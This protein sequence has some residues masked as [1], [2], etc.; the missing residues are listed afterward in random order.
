MSG[1][2]AGLRQWHNDRW[3]HLVANHGCGRRCCGHRRWDGNFVGVGGNAR[4][5][6]GLRVGFVS[7]SRRHSSGQDDGVNVNPCFHRR[8]FSRHAVKSHG[9][10]QSF[11][12]EP[13][14]GLSPPVLRVRRNMKTARPPTTA[15][16]ATPMAKALLRLISILSD[17][18]A[19][20]FVVVR[21]AAA[22]LG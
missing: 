3:F 16:N 14:M 6:A 21:G 13:S 8:E 22:I 10:N 20:A 11:F 5:C 4:G 12:I 15:R 17:R 2:G 7:Q 9:R 19:M 1:N 18:G